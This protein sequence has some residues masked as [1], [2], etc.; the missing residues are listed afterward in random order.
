MK[1]I[2]MIIFVVAV[3]AIGAAAAITVY[4]AKFH[5]KYITVCD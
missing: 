3:A 4:K 1:K 5:K 2:M